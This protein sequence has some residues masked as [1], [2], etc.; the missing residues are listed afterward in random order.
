MS[1]RLSAIT[2][3]PH[4][5]RDIGESQVGELME[6]VTKVLPDLSVSSTRG[7][8][9]LVSPDQLEERLAAI[10]TFHRHLLP[11]A[12]RQCPSRCLPCLTLTLENCHCL[13]LQALAAS[14]QGNARGQHEDAGEAL[15]VPRA[16]LDSLNCVV[17]Q[18]NSGEREE[19]RTWLSAPKTILRVLVAVFQHFLQCSEASPPFPQGYQGRL[20]ELFEECKRI[21]VGLEEALGRGG[22]MD[23][24]DNDDDDDDEE[25]L[26]DVVHLLADLVRALPRLDSRFFVRMARLFAEVSGRRRDLARTG[27]FGCRA[28]EVLS[29]T[30]GL[31]LE[32]VEAVRRLAASLAGGGGATS[33]TSHERVRR[34]EQHSRK[35][36]LL[37]RLAKDLCD[38]FC[39]E[40]GSDFS[41]L[42]R[43]VSKALSLND[44]S[45]EFAEALSVEV[46]LVT[47]DTASYI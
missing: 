17:D 35:L 12:R 20:R 40:L 34:L 47:Y 24:G 28:R 39:D 8:L 2:E 26:Q 25:N 32:Q 1:V 18:L 30:A 45:V 43:A 22:R 27:R 29:T 5:L 42:V 4:A 31:A 37:L 14:A 36:E 16:V 19:V 46:Y 21:M 7:H 10:R 11:L 15:S 6:Q 13:V 9:P 33:T 41:V 44:A 38:I 23:C 3:D